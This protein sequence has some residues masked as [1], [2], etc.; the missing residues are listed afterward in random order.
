MYVRVVSP[1]R[2]V[3]VAAGRAGACEA[4]PAASGDRRIR[5]LAPVGHGSVVVGPE[6]RPTLVVNASAPSAPLLPPPVPDVD[7]DVVLADLPASPPSLGGDDGQSTL[8]ALASVAALTAVGFLLIAM[9]ALVTRFL[10]GS[11]NP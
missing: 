3:P 1:R 2:T 6:A 5:L 9:L 10:R 4:A 7:G 8:E 11:W